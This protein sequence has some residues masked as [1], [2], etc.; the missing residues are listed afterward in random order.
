MEQAAMEQVA[1]SESRGCEKSVEIQLQVIGAAL[2][3]VAEEMGAVLVPAAAGVLSALGLV[4]SEERRDHVRSYVCPLDEAGELPRV[5][6][7]TG[8]EEVVAVEQ[9]QRRVSHGCLSG[10]WLARPTPRVVAPGGWGLG[11]EQRRLTPNYVPE[12]PS[13]DC[14]D[15]GTFQ[16]PLPR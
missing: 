11:T 14:A 13:R 4:A 10:P 1:R 7:P 6:E 3:A 2:R 15:S 16:A 9:I 5:P 8:V 12:R